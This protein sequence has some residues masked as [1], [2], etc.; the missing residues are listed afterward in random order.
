MIPA[1]SHLGLLDDEDIL[2]DL[3]ALELSALDHEGT[4]LDPY[5]AMLQEMEDRLMSAAGTASHGIRQGEI[6]AD[7]LGGDYGFAGDRK[8]YGAPLN[9]DMI[10]VLDRRRGLPVSLSILYVALA[11]RI[12]WTAFALNTPGHVLVRI[13]ESDVSAVIDP[14]NGGAPVPS[15]HV[16][17]LLARALGAHVI[18]THEDMAP[19]SNRMVLVRLLLNQ[20]TRAEQ[21]GDLARAQTIYERMAVI[22]PLHPQGW[23]ELARLQWQ[24]GQAE[25]ARDSLSA[26]LEITRDPTQR[27][28]ISALLE[29]FARK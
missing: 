6:L 5:I 24:A 14:F 27:A 28:H 19:L 26:M 13:G 11:R 15:D 18:L 25:K 8:A 9:A 2:L 16:G 20:A 29:A 10:R 22:A 4:S 12:G 1:I 3:A 17:E 7:L 23:W 21:G